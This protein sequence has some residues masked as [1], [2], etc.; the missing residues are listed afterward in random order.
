MVILESIAVY[1]IVKNR[2]KIKEKFV[3]AKSN[4]VDRADVLKEGI[5]YRFGY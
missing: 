5:R 4:I 3:R 2:K 1:T